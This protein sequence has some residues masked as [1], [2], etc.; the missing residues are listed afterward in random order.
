MWKIA[1]VNDLV[2]GGDGL[3]RA[4]TLCTANDTTNR[5]ITKLYLLA[6]N[7]NESL[8]DTENQQEHSTTPVNIPD[9]PV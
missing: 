1:V 4:A 9:S 6:L 5:P 7:K 3:A 2:M 8:A